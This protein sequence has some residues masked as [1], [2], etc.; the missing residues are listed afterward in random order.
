MEY[1]SARRER[2]TLPFS[3]TQMDVLVILLSELRQAEKSKHCMMSH[4]KN[5]KKAKIVETESRMMV[6]RGWR[7]GGG[8]LFKGTNWELIDQ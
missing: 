5:L 7:G 1:H 4:M 2:E 3:T 8:M 6:P